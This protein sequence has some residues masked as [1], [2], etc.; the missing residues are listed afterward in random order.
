[1]KSLNFW[2]CFSFCLGSLILVGFIPR[3][4]AQIN[5]AESRILFQL[6]KYFEYPNVLQSW[7]KWTDFCFLP[8]S[9]SVTIVCSNGHI[10]ELTVIG[11]KTSPSHSST[12]LK[13]GKFVV[14]QQTL[15]KKFSIDSLFTV[16]TKLTSLKKLSLVSL[17]I[18]GPLPSK[19][20]RFHA[21]ELLNISSNFIYGEIPSHISS[22]KTL[23]SLNLADNLITGKFPDL[24]TLQDLQELDLSNNQI[25]PKFPSLGTNLVSIILRNNSLRSQIPSQIKNLNQLQRFDASANNLIGPLPSF[26]FSIPALWYLNLA[27]NQLTGELPKST[28]C[29]KRLWFVDI[30]RNLLVGQLPSCIGTE[31]YKYR[32]V[33][34]V[35]NCLSGSRFQHPVSFCQ[36]EALAVIPPAKQ[37]AGT[38]KSSGI[39][40]G[41]IF[42]IIGGTILFAGTLVSLIWLIYKRKHSGNAENHIKYDKSVGGKLSTRPSP[43]VDSKYGPKSM[44]MPNLGLPSY[45]SFTLEEVEEATNHFDQVNLIEEGSQGQLYR[46][47]LQSGSA[48]LIRCIKVKDKHSSKTLKQH[49]EAISQLRHQ[50][51]VC[52]L[53]H[54]VVTYKERHQGSTI[55]VVFEHVTNGSLREHLT[56]WRRKDRLKW[57]QRMTISMGIAKGVQFLHT[58][59]V[60]G[61]FG[62]EIKIENVLLDESL[63]PKVSN[64]RIPLPY[65]VVTSNDQNAKNSSNPDKD[66]I[67]NLGV[68]LLEL[69]TGRQ[70]TSDKQVEELKL[71]LERSL[72]ESASALQHAVD[73]SMRGTYAYQSIKTAVELALNCL[74]NEPSRRPPM[75]DVVWHLQYSIQAQQTWT[76]S[77]NLALHSGNQGLNK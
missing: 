18:W 70:I 6:Q 14:S 54:C 64:Y 15:S 73:L 36:R 65:K 33:L 17:G 2:V 53:G 9:S 59:M 4:N 72:A 25:G 34:S 40:F 62:N 29:G 41:M 12:S 39:K 35:W 10:T 26:V 19:I 5:S 77:G 21:L 47:L 46:G 58:G 63:T 24:S 57:P 13:D 37:I 42:G 28:I 69:L 55:F 43:I 23:K 3:S 51:L 60:P 8:P 1:M 16:L 67:Y 38:Q 49:M 30:S 11:N 48:V 76:S 45:Q 74:S 32:K 75:E 52:V 50:N 68:I 27:E 61:V 56:D 71:E 31:S 22:L 20:S 7:G 66:D 44:R